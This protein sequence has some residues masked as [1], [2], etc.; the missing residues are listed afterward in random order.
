MPDATRGVEQ[1]QSWVS[2]SQ[3]VTKMKKSLIFSEDIP[4]LES[5]NGRAGQHVVH[6]AVTLH[7]NTMCGKWPIT[8]SP[9]RN[10][11]RRGA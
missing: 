2:A 1:R 8:S 6:H 5:T 11:P 4:V 3:Y 10:L 9:P 7:N